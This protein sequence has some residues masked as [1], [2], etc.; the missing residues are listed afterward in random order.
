[1]PYDL[2]LCLQRGGSRSEIL[3]LISSH[4]GTTTYREQHALKCVFQTSSCD[5]LLCRAIDNRAL[6]LDKLQALPFLILPRLRQALHGSAV[7]AAMA[8]TVT[9]QRP[10][11]YL[12]P[13]ESL[14]HLQTVWPASLSNCQ[15]AADFCVVSYK[16]L[17]M[18][19]TCLYFFCLPFSPCS[20]SLFYTTGG[21]L[22]QYACVPQSCK[23]FQLNC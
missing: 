7:M 19:V 23:L 11:I 16:S 14:L 5:S 6:A 4:P 18:T 3:K 8:V 12:K 9:A 20:G 2:R 1:M 15:S 21:L 22:F 10:F 17:C 13:A